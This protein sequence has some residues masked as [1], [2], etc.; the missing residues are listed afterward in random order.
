MNIALRPSLFL[1]HTFTLPPVLLQ[2][3]QRQPE[4]H[5]TE[6]IPVG[7]YDIPESRCARIRLSHGTIQLPGYPD[8]RPGILPGPSPPRCQ[9]GQYHPA[10]PAWNRE[11]HLRQANLCRSRRSHEKDHPGLCELPD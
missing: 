1:N 3:P 2:I 4:G 10:R 7:P 8:E 6:S 5:A 11:D 9:A